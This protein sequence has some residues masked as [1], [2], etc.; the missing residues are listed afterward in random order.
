M[1]LRRSIELIGLPIFRLYQWYERRSIWIQVAFGLLITV[2][3]LGV[4][5]EIFGRAS[6]FGFVLIT[7][8]GPALGF[9]ALAQRSSTTSA[10]VRIGGSFLCAILFGLLL[11]RINEVPMWLGLSYAIVALIIGL[12]GRAAFVRARP[13]K[14]PVDMHF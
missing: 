7:I 14:Q 10:I 8:G 3:F 5:N 6:V 12:I 4:T 11:S 9:W 2:G 13:W 1:R